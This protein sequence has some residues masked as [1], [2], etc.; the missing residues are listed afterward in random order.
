[1]AKI[2]AAFSDD[3]AVD[4]YDRNFDI[5]PHHILQTDT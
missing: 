4:F 3:N 5:P 2:A 1:M